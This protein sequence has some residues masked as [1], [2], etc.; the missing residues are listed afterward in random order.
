MI[1]WIVVLGAVG[2][3]IKDKPR[4]SQAWRSCRRGRYVDGDAGYTSDVPDSGLQ[5]RPLAADRPEA[6]DLDDVSVFDPIAEGPRRDED[7]VGEHEPPAEI[8][9]EVDLGGRRRW[10]F[11]LLVA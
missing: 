9:R 4:F 2:P 1:G 7:R 3:W 5:R 11:F 10:R 6:I 8:D